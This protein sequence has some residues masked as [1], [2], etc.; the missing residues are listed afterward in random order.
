MKPTTFVRL[1]A[2]SL[3]LG[4]LAGACGG[5]G[6]QKKKS[7]ADPAVVG[8]TRRESA[9]RPGAAEAD[10]FAHVACVQPARE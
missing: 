1:G 4:L 8:A 9:P 6:E 7:S 3:A 10:R 5:G 2:I